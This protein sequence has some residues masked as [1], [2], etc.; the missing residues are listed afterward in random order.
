MWW[1]TRCPHPPR[2]RGTSRCRT[3]RGTTPSS[4]RS[5]GQRAPTARWAEGM[6]CCTLPVLGSAGSCTGMLRGR[7]LRSLAN[8]CITCF[9]VP[10]NRLRRRRWP[11]TWSSG[12]SWRRGCPERTPRCAPPACSSRCSPASLSRSGEDGRCLDGWEAG[13]AQNRVQK[14]V[15]IE[16]MHDELEGIFICSPAQLPVPAAPLPHNLAHSVAYTL[17]VLPALQAGGGA[18]A[19]QAGSDQRRQRQ[20]AP[21]AAQRGGSAGGRVWQRSARWRRAG[22]GLGSWLGACSSAR[23][24]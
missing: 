15:N 3:R 14:L 13:C 21:A 7:H 8:C 20:A 9:H 12:P 22:A 6:F 19:G 23:G 2:R 4:C 24:Q 1:R 10:P 11:S 18:A 17:S 5:C 16:L